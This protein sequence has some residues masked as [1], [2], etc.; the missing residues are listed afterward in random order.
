MSL[1]KNDKKPCPVCGGATPRIF[2]TKIEGQPLCSDCA[3]R[4]SAQDEI[5]NS[6]TVEDVRAH[7]AFRDRNDA[8]KATFSESAKIK[9]GWGGEAVFDEADRLFY[10]MQNAN[11]MLFHG[12]EAASVEIRED[13]TLI[14]RADRNGYKWRDTTL[15]DQVSAMSAQIN[16]SNMTDRMQRARDAEHA[17]DTRFSDPMQKWHIALTLEHPYWNRIETELGGPGWNNSEP[18]CAQFLHEYDESIKKL[19]DFAGC[20][21]RTCFPE[22]LERERTQR[23]ASGAANTAPAASAADEIKKF[24]ELLDAGAIT[25]EEFDAKKKQLLGL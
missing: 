10:F 4:L 18:N 8:E 3:A 9:F 25:Q 16:F 13:D 24:K 19:R 20:M 17:T 14:F 11:G 22:V 6:M 21:L 15:R 7:F 23:A 1:F 2:S 12:S 5:K